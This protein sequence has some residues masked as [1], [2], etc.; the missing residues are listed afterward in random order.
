MFWIFTFKLCRYGI[1]G[2]AVIFKRTELALLY[3]FN[4][5]MFVK[6]WLIGIYQVSYTQNITIF[7]EI[8]Q[9]ILTVSGVC[10][11]SEYNNERKSA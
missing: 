2:L 10:F 6:L 8:L 7:V 11:K 9:T 4:Y 5:Y 1:T 3:L